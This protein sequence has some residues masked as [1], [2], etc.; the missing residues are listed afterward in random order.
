MMLGH[1]DQPRPARTFGPFAVTVTGEATASGVEGRTLDATQL[2]HLAC[3]AMRAARFIEMG[4]S[5][6]LLDARP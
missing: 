2:L 1:D 3:E 5:D 6:P 4:L